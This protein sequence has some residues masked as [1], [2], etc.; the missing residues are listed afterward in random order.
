MRVTFICIITFP[1]EHNKNNQGYILTLIYCNWQT[2]G[3]TLTFVVVGYIIDSSSIV[4][5]GWGST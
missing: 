1:L 5:R 2:P 4:K 3:C